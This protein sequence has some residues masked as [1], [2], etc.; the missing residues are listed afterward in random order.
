MTHPCRCCSSGN[1]CHCNPTPCCHYSSLLLCHVGSGLKSFVAKTKKPPPLWP[2]VVTLRALAHRTGAPAS[3]KALPCDNTCIF[4]SHCAMCLE[5]LCEIPCGTNFQHV[6]C[7]FAGAANGGY[8]EIKHNRPMLMEPSFEMRAPKMSIR[9]NSS[10]RSIS[11]AFAY[12]CLTW[13]DLI[14]I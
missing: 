12:L 8:D 9:V 10:S 5:C 11:S 7:R 3:N 13:C 14:S 1:A 6:V 4:G 2:D